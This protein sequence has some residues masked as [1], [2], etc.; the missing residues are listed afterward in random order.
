MFTKVLTV[1]IVVIRASIE[2]LEISERKQQA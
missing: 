1:V 2:I